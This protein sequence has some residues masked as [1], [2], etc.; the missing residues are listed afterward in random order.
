MNKFNEYQFAKYNGGNKSVKF[1][2]ILKLTHPKG[3]Y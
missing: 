3:K 2:D 1:S